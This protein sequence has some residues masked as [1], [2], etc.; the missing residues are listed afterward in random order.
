M[1][2]GTYDGQISCGEIKRYGDFGIAAADALAGEMM[3]VDGTWYQVLP[4]GSVQVPNDDLTVPFGMATFFEPG[5]TFSVGR[6]DNYQELRTEVDKQLPSRNLFYAVKVEGT[7]AKAKNRSFAK[8]SKPY[9]NQAVVTDEQKIFEARNT[10]GTFVGFWFPDYIS[11]IN[12]PGLHLHYLSKDKDQGGHTLDIAISSASVFL[13]PLHGYH[14]A[15]PH[16]ADFLKA[17]LKGDKTSEIRKV[18][19][20]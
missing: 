3:L 19:G 5:L 2:V 9:R 10:E 20:R 7:F 15:L 14:I 8:Q 11:G 4:D 12:L 17:D 13:Q 16:S 6:T 1:V 18:H